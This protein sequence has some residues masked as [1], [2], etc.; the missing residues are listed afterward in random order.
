MRKTKANPDSPTVHADSV[1]L[2]AIVGAYEK[3]DIA[4]ANAP[5]ARLNAAIDEFTLLKMVSE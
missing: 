2:N 5:G 3:R 1:T 4:T